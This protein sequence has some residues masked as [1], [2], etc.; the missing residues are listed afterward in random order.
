MRVRWDDGLCG[1]GSSVA[2]NHHAAARCCGAIQR[3]LPGMR[4]FHRRRNWL[5]VGLMLAVA[6]AAIGVSLYRHGYVALPSGPVPACDGRYRL[7]DLPIEDRVE[8]LLGCMT[9]DEKIGQM[10]LVEKNSIHWKPDIGRYGIG[11]LLSGGGGKPD[12]NTPRGWRDMVEEF[13]T[14]ARRS[15]LGIPLLYGVDAVHGNTNVLGATVFPHNIGL[16]ASRD[17]DLVRRIGAATAREL[18]A[19][20]IHWNFAPSIDVVE[21]TRWGRTFETFGNDPAVVSQMGAAYLGGLQSQAS[22]GAPVIG[23]AKHYVGTGDMEWGT[24]GNPDFKIDQ[25]VTDVDD[26]TLRRVHLPPFKAAVDAGVSSVMVGHTTWNG[27]ELAASSYLLT[28][29]LKGELGFRGFVVSDWYGVYEIPG[30]EY[31]A[32]VTA[33]NAGV[34]MV[35]LP[36]DYKSF[37]GYVQRALAEGEVSVDRLDDAVRRILR[38]KF[39]AGLFDGRGAG[40]SPD[41]QFGSAEHRQLAREAVRKSLVLLDDSGGV[42]PLRKDVGR[43]VV[44]GSSAHNLGRQSGGWTVEWQGIDGN[45]IPG[46]TILDAIRQAVPSTATVEYS[47][48]GK[49]SSGLAKADVGIAVVGEAPYAEGWGDSE[50]PALTTEDL[51]S[52]ARVRAASKKTLVIVVSGRP[53]AMPRSARGDALVAAWLPGTEGGGVADVLFGDYPFTGKLPLAWP[54]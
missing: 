51:R 47:P 13:Q 17:Y 8:A 34:D 25:G 41:S 44:A 26:A 22:A 43:I 10:A 16:G 36:Y 42:L 27:E 32:A 37:T 33:I 18:V 14:Y 49:F 19:T 52:I 12:E 38:A 21:D 50:R 54:L 31:R 2:G 11:A 3:I 23:T 15:R 24:S 39:E 48:D 28:D 46:T 4:F 35:M 45:W 53:L 20:G 7:A 6:A 9:Q 5:K 29:V 40:S 1:G 30:G